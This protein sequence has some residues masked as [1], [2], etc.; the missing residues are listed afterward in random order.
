MIIF[1]DSTGLD[2]G[3]ELE[4]GFFKEGE[5]ELAFVLIKVALLHHNVTRR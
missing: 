1:H 3:V 5:I 2:I 4:L